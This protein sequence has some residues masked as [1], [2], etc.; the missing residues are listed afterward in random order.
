MPFLADINFG[1]LNQDDIQKQLQSIVRQL[2]EWGREISNE[3]RTKITND[4]SGTKRLLIGYQENGF[5]NGNVGVKMSQV[6]K[7]VLTA[8]SDEL[9]FSTDFNTFKIIESGTAQVVKPANTTFAST[10]VSHNQ[11]G[12]GGLITISYVDPTGLE[13][14]QT[15]HLE[16]TSA[17]VL[18][19]YWN[20]STTPTT[21]VFNVSTPNVTGGLY[22]VGFTS[23]F[24]YYI[25][26]ETAS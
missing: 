14:V 3:E 13:L 26:R 22:P 19:G 21:V 17:G 15:P 1:P 25:L 7:D 24:K 10:S 4:D 11:S 23:T 9:I 2:N 12:V 20:I 18:S 8:E 16:F 6:D 5:A